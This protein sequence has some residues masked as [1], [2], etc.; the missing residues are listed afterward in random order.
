MDWKA[1]SPQLDN[2]GLDYA[3][4][5]IQCK[6]KGKSFSLFNFEILCHVHPQKKK[7]TF[8]FFILMIKLVIIDLKYYLIINYLDMCL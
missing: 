2:D 1:R 7:K 4:S 6:T 5:G 3:L 8:F